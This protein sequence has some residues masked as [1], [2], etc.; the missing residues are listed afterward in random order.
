MDGISESS[1]RTTTAATAG[2]EYTYIPDVAT[3]DYT[4]DTYTLDDLSNNLTS[5]MISDAST[6]DYMS[7]VYTYETTSMRN[8]SSASDSLD[9]M[10]SLS[11]VS[12]MDTFPVEAMWADDSSLSSDV[13]SIHAY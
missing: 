13:T 4:S 12:N 10:T 5:E 1:V 9:Q 7:D 6:S 3:S 2:P 11:S 8:S